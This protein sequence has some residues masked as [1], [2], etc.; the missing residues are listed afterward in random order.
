MA[1]DKQLIPVF[2]PTLANMLAHAEKLKGSPLTETEV[3]RI[4]DNA[5]CIMMKAS[6][7]D[8]LIE[9][10]GFRDV[11]PENCWADW[12]RLRVEMT[13]NGF[14]PKIILCVPGGKDFPKTCEAIL[15]EAGNEHEWRKRE[16]RMREAFEASEFRVRPSLEK[17]DWELIDQH[18][19]VLYVLSDNYPA[20]QAPTVSLSMLQ[21]GRQLLEAEG[22]AIK[23][24]SSGIAHSRARWIELANQADGAKDAQTRWSALFDAFVQFP[25]Q[26]ET[27]YYTCGMHLLGVPDLIVDTEVLAAED[28]VELFGVFALYLLAECPPGSFAS[29]HT[30]SA[31]KKAPR[32]R[33]VW[34]PCTE[35]EEDEFFFNPF[36]RWRFTPTESQ[37]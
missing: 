7:A 20:A 30:F 5:P 32:Y 2:M 16:K 24:E 6:D 3:I 15:T 4:R 13:G 23:C 18:K 17:A 28:A 35:Y 27:D 34:E 36:G 26:S 14:L 8:K 11:N 37:P 1:T 21:L 12:H 10:R 25:V 22:S 9:T 19:T 33:V 29:G 31:D